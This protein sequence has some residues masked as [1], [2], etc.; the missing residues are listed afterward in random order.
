MLERE[1]KNLNRSSLAAFRDWFR[2]YDSEV[3]DRQI[4]GDI[5]TGKFEKLAR[6]AVAAR[7]TGKTREL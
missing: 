2:K 6:E 1:V 5:H 4:E 3:W 7:K